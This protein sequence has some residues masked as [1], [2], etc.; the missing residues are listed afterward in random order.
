MRRHGRRLGR[1]AEAHAR[2]HAAGAKRGHRGVHRRELL[3]AGAGPAHAAHRTASAVWTGIGAAG[4][5][6]YGMAF[7]GEPRE[8]A[9][10]VSL[11]LIVAGIVGLKLAGGK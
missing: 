4:T 11:L 10:L 9:R 1:G 7:L 5:A 8:A 6:V 3:A 2:L